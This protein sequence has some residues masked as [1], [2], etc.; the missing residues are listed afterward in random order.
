MT[1]W[2]L[3]LLYLV[4]VLFVGF[5]AAQLALRR[6][7]PMRAE[8][9][10]PLSFGLGLGAQCVIFLLFLLVF[11]R[12]YIIPAAG[13]LLVFAVAAIW[14]ARRE[15]PTQF[16]GPEFLQLP[17]EPRSRGI[18]VLMIALIVFFLAML[19]S[20]AAS[21]PFTSYD[22]RAI[23][24]YKAK[25][26]LHENTIFTDA[27]T[28]PYRVHYHRNYPPLVPFTEYSIYSIF[29]E[30]AERK[31]RFLFSTFFLFQVLYFHGILRRFGTGKIMAT[32]FPLLYC[33]TPF[34][35]DWFE[36]DGGALNS[37]A[38][39]I[40]LSFLT[41]VAA[42][43][44]L[45]WW[46]ERQRWQV[47]VAVLFSALALMTKQEGIV[48]IAALLGANLLYSIFGTVDLRRALVFTFQLLACSILAALPWILV[49]SYL[50]NHYDEDYGAQ[51][52]AQ[53]LSRIHTRIPIVTERLIREVMWLYKWN[54]Y[55][56]AYVGLL[57]FAIS[58]WFRRRDFWLD[59]VILLWASAYFFTYL[60]SPL[61]LIFH[62]DTSISRLMSHVL[63]LV[64]IRL[65]LF[66][67]ESNENAGVSSPA[68]PT[69]VSA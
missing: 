18:Y 30:V 44:A 5:G 21:Y 43:S 39:D 36:V 19:Y 52:S 4:A 47:V 54:G 46:K 31:V 14:S 61:N 26:L 60:V 22:G 65:A 32:V 59:A 48:A 66:L 37:G 2:L 27:F 64:L 68:D 23:W 56:L 58:G 17:S 40:P 38:V 29:N 1:G 45:L 28:D 7:E 50:P 53:V 15:I 57:F 11:G 8:L 35:D 13:I 16:L 34:R 63:P 25:I 67:H 41:M 20:N 24:S 49:R 55:W 6:A 9:W 3:L 12:I 42:I 10:L 33:A 69:G 62:L 51:M